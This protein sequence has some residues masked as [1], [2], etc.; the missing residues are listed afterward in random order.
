MKAINDKAKCAGQAGD[1]T[2]ICGYRERCARYKRPVGDRQVWSGF[3]K[4]E[5]NC[6]QYESLGGLQGR[7]EQVLNVAEMEMMGL[8]YV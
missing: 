5:L 6:P 3:W 1:G 2:K 8:H 4:A 7:S